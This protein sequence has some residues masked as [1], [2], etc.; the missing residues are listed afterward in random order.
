MEMNNDDINITL[1]VICPLIAIFTI[2]II[3]IYLKSD[4]LK[5]Y[6]CYFNIYFCLIITLDNILRII[7]TK[8]NPDHASG[9]C[10]AQAFAL[11]FFDKQFLISIT[12]YSII[13]YIIMINPKLYEDHMKEIYIIFPIIGFVLSLT[14]T[15]IFFATGKISNSNMKYEI[16]YVQTD[17]TIKIILDNIYTSLLLLIDI[18]CNIRTIINI[19]R[20]MKDFDTKDNS[21]RKKKLRHHLCRFIFDLF[22]NVCTFGYVLILINKLFGYKSMKDFLYIILCFIN[23]LFFTLNGE[24]YRE[25]MR[26]ITCNKVEKYKIKDELEKKLTKEHNEDEEEEEENDNV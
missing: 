13:N 6:P 8:E 19:S 15:I 18:F 2:F 10:K 21:H 12:G 14:L 16:C 24:L 23:E 22:L 11:S 3:I 26:T 25:F 5:S 7:P 20:L 1:Y 4:S 17:N 9:G